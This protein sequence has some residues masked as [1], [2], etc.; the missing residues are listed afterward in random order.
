MPVKLLIVHDNPVVCE[1]IRGMVDGTEFQIVGMERTEHLEVAHAQEVAPDVVV[2]G[3]SHP[4][5]VD[6]AHIAAFKERAP[7]AAIVLLVD[8]ILP[9]D[10]PDDFARIV[11]CISQN[12]NA[13]LLNTFLRESHRMNLAAIQRLGANGSQFSLQ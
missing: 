11:G 5:A 12:S 7:K 1:G 3:V 9:D 8:E 10:G 6:A 2:L 13:T 4:A